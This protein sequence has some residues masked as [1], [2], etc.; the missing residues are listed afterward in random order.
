MTENKKN[1]PPSGMCYQDRVLHSVEAPLYNSGLFNI[2][3]DDNAPKSTIKGKKLY[4]AGKWYD[5]VINVSLM[6]GEN[7]VEDIEAVIDTDAYYSNINRSILYKLGCIEPYMFLSQKTI[8]YGTVQSPSFM[9]NMSINGFEGII[10]DGFIETPFQTEY[11][12]L[13]GT[14]FLKLCD[15]HFF[16]KRGQFELEF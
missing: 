1:I 8:M 2:I 16:G 12:V 7:K 15:L 6:Y 11:P 14:K 10:E 5:C 9:I 4:D 13:L 3:R